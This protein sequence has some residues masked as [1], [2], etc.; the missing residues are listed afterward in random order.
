MLIFIIVVAA[1]ALA[2]ASSY[3]IAL[4]SNLFGAPL[5]HYARVWISIGSVALGFVTAV[6][7]RLELPAG[8]LSIP[9]QLLVLGSAWAI[10]VTAC[11]ALWRNIR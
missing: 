3:V 4:S 8:A 1:L 6:A 10:V 5:G 9:G 11:V 7:L 2:L